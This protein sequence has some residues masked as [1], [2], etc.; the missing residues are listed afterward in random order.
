[1]AQF[2]TETGFA[3]KT[4]QEIRADLE[5]RLK[6]VFGP[7]FETSVD[8]PNGQL[9]GALSMALSNVWELAQEVYDSRDPAQ[10]TGVS[11]DFAAAI[12]SIFRKEAT[13]CA[14]TAVLYTL[15]AS[16][17]IPAGSRAMRT[18]GSLLFTLDR[19]VTISRAACKY[20][21]I[22]DDGSELNT[23][24]VF[25]FTF[26][27][28]TMENTL[29]GV[30]NLQKLHTLIWA[31]GGY[32]ELRDD[33][34]L[35]WG[36]TSVGI[37]GTLPDDFE[38]YAGAEG[39]FTAVTT[40]PQTC[41]I[42]ELDNIPTTVQGWDMVRNYVAGV[43]G[44]S[45]ETDAELRIRRA[46]AARA[47]KT[48]GTDPALEAHLRNDVRGVVAARVVSNRKMV[49]DSDGRPPKSFEA[50][51]SGG[52]DEDVA[53]CIWKNQAS[54]IESYGNHSVEITDDNG[55]GQLI[56]FS[57]AQARF[58][59]VRVVYHLYSEEQFPGEDSLRA[60]LVEWANQEYDVDRDVIPDRIYSAL[61]PPYIN[62]VGQATITV[63]VT[64]SENDTPLFGDSV[65]PI[66]PS[67]FAS[68][69]ADRVVLVQAV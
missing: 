15:D 32:A 57:R 11:L 3:R 5:A 23:E 43:P 7:S 13:A 27:D 2:V 59:W 20:L 66:G 30:S 24:Y 34:L 68:L 4:L 39:E 31:A 35:V 22:V 69:V 50:L 62:G 49:T 55:D 64:S 17:T 29:P 16:A 54:G 48:T 19:A 14:V 21:F 56:S 36:D 18:R 44:T 37:T 8:S 67:Q 47:I 52:T 60:S 12:N 42:G 28:V 25:H 26:G 10:A 61:Y 1:M 6:Q 40:G 53:R 51:V 38:I 9:V 65:I 45:I 41:E 58:L 63:A 46:Q 33:G